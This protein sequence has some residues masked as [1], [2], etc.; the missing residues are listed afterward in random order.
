M[1]A[2]RNRELTSR[3][4]VY[5]TFENLTSAEH[6][7]FVKN[8]LLLE[9]EQNDFLLLLAHDDRII[10]SPKQNLIRNFF[11][12]LDENTVYFPSYHCC[13]AKNYKNVTHTIEKVETYKTHEFFLTS[14]KEN[15]PTNMSGMILPLHA[16]QDAHETIRFTGTG[17][18]YEHLVATSRQVKTVE[19][20]NKFNVLVGER[21][22]SDGLTLT[23]MKHAVAKLMYLINFLKK[24]R[25][26]VHRI[27]LILCHLLHA[28]FK[29]VNL[30]L[31]SWIKKFFEI[32]T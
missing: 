14:L 7:E 21:P 13:S 23:P 31:N 24:H 12:N 27:P 30:A 6:G 26:S 19:F 17:A 8:K 5:R 18:R 9:L 29:V 11:N 1:L 4:T 20:H 2:K 3:Y 10:N 32:L 15:I 16:C 22:D 25:I 28:M